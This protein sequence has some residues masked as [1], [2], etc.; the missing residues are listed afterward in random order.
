MSE[1]N[2][3]PVLNETTEQEMVVSKKRSKR[4]KIRF[5]HRHPILFYIFWTG[6]ISTVLVVSGA[7]WY[8]ENTLE[9][10][11]RITEQMLKSDGTSNM[12]DA[13]GNIIWSSTE[14]RRD[15]VK[16]DNISDLYKKML[17]ATEDETFETDGG[18]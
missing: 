13:K 6:V 11:P 3:E 1:N 4:N 7:A 10:T 18:F 15:Y 5:R 2:K 17:L 16:A 14:I 8:V 12:Y 9:K